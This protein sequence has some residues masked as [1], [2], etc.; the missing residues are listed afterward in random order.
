MR[1]RPLGEGSPPHTSQTFCSEQSQQGRNRPLLTKLSAAPPREKSVNNNNYDFPALSSLFFGQEQ[2][3]VGCPRRAAADCTLTYDDDDDV[4]GDDGD[5]HDDDH[6]IEG[7]DDENI[8]NDDKKKI[9]PSGSAP[10]QTS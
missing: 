5:D 6:D 9:V 8:I 4:D 3:W 2:W 1:A 10:P 7:N